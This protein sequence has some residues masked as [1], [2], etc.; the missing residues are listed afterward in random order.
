[1]KGS[2]PLLFLSFLVLLIAIA[3]ACGASPPQ[4]TLQSITLAPATA[5]ANGEPVQFTAT[6]IYNT[7]PIQVTPQS[8]TWGACYQNASTTDVSVTSNG[9]AQ[10]ASG[11]M[12]TFTVFAY[13]TVGQV[14]SGSVTACG[15][16]GCYVT[17]TAQLT[18]P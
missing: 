4:R 8:A 9:L 10:C 11:A 6:G 13:D 3:L 5:D 2:V 15:G 12:G 17:G 1:M 14:C 7:Q 16:G 18:C